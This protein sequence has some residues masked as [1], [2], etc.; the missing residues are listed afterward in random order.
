MSNRLYSDYRV[1]YK[2]S[3]AVTSRPLML[4]MLQEVE[5]MR[6][7]ALAQMIRS[8]TQRLARGY[9]ALRGSIG[10]ARIAQL[11]SHFE[12]SSDAGNGPHRSDIPAVAAGQI[13][14]ARGIVADNEHR[15][16]PR[17]AA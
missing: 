4:E 3:E 13:D 10:R 17:Q 11:I 12:G 6:A 1:P 9:S 5:D 7:L 16:D 8:L 14:I 15:S 2:F